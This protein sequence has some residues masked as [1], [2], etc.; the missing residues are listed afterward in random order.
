M[1][2]SHPSSQGPFAASAN[3]NQYEATY[4]F[5]GG[6]LSVG[7]G[8]TVTCTFVGTREG[9]LITGISD[10]SLTFVGGNATVSYF[11][12]SS[13]GRPFYINGPSG[14]NTAVVSLDGTQNDF[15]F[16]DISDP[17]N[18]YAFCS[19]TGSAASELND[20]LFYIELDVPPEDLAGDLTYQN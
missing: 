4:T 19:Y 1:C 13:E 14:V 11:N 16:L 9:N 10:V 7:A 8:S 12:Y 15:Q 20:G 2:A 6:I 3:A 17:A 18:E 5:G